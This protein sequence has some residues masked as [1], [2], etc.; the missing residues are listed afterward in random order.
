M[1]VNPM[2][3]RTFIIRSQTEY[4]DATQTIVTRYILGTADAGKRSGFTDIESLL[5][6][7]RAELLH[8]RREVTTRSDHH[9]GKGE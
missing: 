5:E 6:A 7:L 2:V 4:A 1:N 8:I 3:A 9:L